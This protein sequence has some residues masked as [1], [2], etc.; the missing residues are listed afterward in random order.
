MPELILG[1]FKGLAFVGG[2]WVI[3][4]F[5]LLLMSLMDDWF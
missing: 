4:I 5:G 1:L 2:L 3:G